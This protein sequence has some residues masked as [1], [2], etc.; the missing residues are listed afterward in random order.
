MEWKQITLPKDLTFSE[1]SRSNR[2]RRG[3]LLSKKRGVRLGRPPLPLDRKKLKKL[4]AQGMTLREM[5]RKLGCSKSCV[6][7]ALTH[8]LS[9][10]IGCTKNCPRATACSP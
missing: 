9:P 5:A 3:M 1:M 10:C 4:A 2:V 6:Q 7:R 8:E